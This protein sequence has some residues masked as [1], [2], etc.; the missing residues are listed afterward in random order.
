MSNLLILT[1]EQKQS[2]DDNGYLHLPGFYSEDEVRELRDEFRAMVTQTENRPKNM[3]YSFME[4]VEGFEVDSFNPKNV[5]GMMDHVLASDFWIHHFSEPRIVSAFVD[6]MGPNI[7]FHNGKVRNKPPGFECTQSWHQDFPYE[8]HSEPDLAA[9]ITYLEATDFEKG[10]TEV[11]PGSHLKGE[12][13]TFDGTRIKDENV[14]EGSWVVCKA[15]PGDVVIIS[16]LVVHR[17]G[18]NYTNTARHAIINEYKTMETVDQWNNRCALAGLPLAR[19]GKP[20]PVSPLLS[21]R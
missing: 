5:V 6:L 16:V 7:D 9:A 12:W 18:H 19:N 20:L 3:S 21:S 15:E 2:Y 4:P 8:R 14:E 11:V 13:E 17:A 10:A 1:P